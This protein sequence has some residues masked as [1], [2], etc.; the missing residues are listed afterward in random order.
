M[1]TGKVARRTAVGDV[2]E[3]LDSPEITALIGEL[4]A[5]RDKRGQK[6]YSTRALVEATGRRMVAEPA[7]VR[8]YAAVEAVLQKGLAEFGRVDVV[9]TTPDGDEIVCGTLGELVRRIFARLNVTLL[10]RPEATARLDERLA[11]VIHQLLENR[12]W[13]FEP[14]SA[15]GRRPGFV[16]DDEF[17]TSCYR[18]FGSKYFYRLGS[19][20]TAAVRSTLTRRA[21]AYCA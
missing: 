16:I 15:G 3:I 12:V 19:I 20:L 14:R 7:D 11:P 21:C 13:R 1:A 17:S 10:A 5:L 2:G 6:G 9:V 4:E 18:A 8:D